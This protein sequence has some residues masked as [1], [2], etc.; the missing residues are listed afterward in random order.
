MMVVLVFLTASL[1]HAGYQEIFEKEFLLADWAG[2]QEKSSACVACHSLENMGQDMLNL[3]RKWRHSWHAANDVSCHDCHGGAP[4][5]VSNSMSHDRGFIGTPD[6]ENVPRLCGTCHIAIMKNYLSSGHG[7]NFCVSPD[8]GPNC[9][10]CHGSHNVQQASID[11]ISEE[12]CSRC[13]S[14][15]RAQ[16]MKQALYAVENKLATIKID[17]DKLRQAG[18]PL[19]DQEKKFFRS[20][21][22]F[23]IIFHTI[24]VELVKEK[25]NEF[26]E[27]L[28]AIEMEIESAN[29]QLAFRRNFSAFLLL[30]FAGMAGVV[31]LL[32]RSDKE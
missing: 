12:M 24:D 31:Y 6:N 19:P 22:E 25:S 1:S 4:E 5:D 20:H 28:A 30:I 16:L 9:V 14:Y 21:S 11:I 29:E 27:K 23:R 15:E 13:H 7:Q 17:L 8:G 10:T 3:V 18:I 2:T 26:T 32:I